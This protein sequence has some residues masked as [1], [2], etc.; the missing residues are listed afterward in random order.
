[1]AAMYLTNYHNTRDEMENSWFYF[2]EEME[3]GGTKNTDRKFDLELKG[4]ET[5]SSEGRLEGWIH[6]WIHLLV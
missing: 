5:L 3:E 4:E 6:S 2:L 1:M